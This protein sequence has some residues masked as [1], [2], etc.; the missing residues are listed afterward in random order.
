MNHQKCA[1][2]AVQQN[3]TSGGKKCLIA[4]KITQGI[5]SLGLNQP[6]MTAQSECG[7]DPC[8]VADP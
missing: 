7:Y 2:D 6:Q 3:P 1:H 4:V 5:E 8:E